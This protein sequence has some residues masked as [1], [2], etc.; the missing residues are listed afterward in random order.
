MIPNDRG[1]T[2]P[3]SRRS[4]SSRHGTLRKLTSRIAA[5]VLRRPRER[6]SHP[7]PATPAPRQTTAV[8]ALPYFSTHPATVALPPDP[9]LTAPPTKIGERVGE[10]TDRTIPGPGGP[11]PLRLYVPDGQGPFPVLLHLHGGGWVG[12]GLDNEDDLCR[13]LASR[14]GALVV[15]LGFRL[16]PAHPYP[17]AV[18]D[19]LAALDW[20]AAHAAEIGGDPAR[21]AVSGRSSGG[22]LAAAVALATRDRGGPALAAQLLLL[23]ATNHNCDTVSYHQNADGYGLTRAAMMTFWDRY[24]ARPEDGE[25]PYASPLRAPDLAG[26]PPA[27]IIT[28]Q[29]DPLRDDGEAYAARLYQA[30]VPVRVTRY[31]EATHGFLGFAATVPSADRALQQAAHFLR[32]TLTR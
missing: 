22:T 6:R 12:G 17:A 10:V 15:S 2:E 23:P 20:L 4:A 5:A 31:L 8:N 26:L 18:E 14:S 9:R 7:V 3:P 13:S 21:L 29:W 28:A 27:L 11:L 16:A 24:L 32:A 1:A 25:E 30:G 19:C